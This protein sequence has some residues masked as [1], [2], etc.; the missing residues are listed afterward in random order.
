MLKMSKI[1]FIAVVL[2]L[3]LTI[4]SGCAGSKS[5]VSSSSVGSTS[6]AV[7]EAA[8]P[9]VDKAKLAAEAAE[10]E[11]HRLREELNRKNKTK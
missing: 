10:F 11:A 6:E 9:E 1:G 8:S 3:S 4:F 2:L 7:P 5:N